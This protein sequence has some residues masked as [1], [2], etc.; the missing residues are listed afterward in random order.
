MGNTLSITLLQVCSVLNF[1]SAEG[2]LSIF[3]RNADGNHQAVEVPGEGNVAD[4]YAAVAVQVGHPSFALSIAGSTLMP[5]TSLAD[6]GIS[7]E[8]VVQIQEGDLSDLNQL[9]TSEW[10]L[11]FKQRVID[12]L[13]Q[14]PGKL[15]RVQV[16]YNSL[17]GYYTE[18]WL[19]QKDDDEIY[20]GISLFAGSSPFHFAALA[21]VENY[22]R[23]DI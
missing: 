18:R 22:V 21:G 12:E 4:L 2:G 23:I 1:A 10:E 9:L 3:V 8:C 5:T 6:S 15:A 20:S 16:V 7:A 11:S 13:S 17:A 19:L 14:F